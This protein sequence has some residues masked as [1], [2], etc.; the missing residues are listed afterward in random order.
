VD[1]LWM[2]GVVTLLGLYIIGVLYL[3]RRCFTSLKLQYN[4]KKS[5]VANLNTYY[6]NAMKDSAETANPQR[7]PGT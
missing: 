7:P 1:R 2:R 4:K 6:T 5:E 3:L